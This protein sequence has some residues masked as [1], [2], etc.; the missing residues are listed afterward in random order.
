[1]YFFHET[2]IQIHVTYFIFP[3]I[4][5]LCKIRKNVF[6]KTSPYEKGFRLTLQIRVDM[7]NY[8]AA[9]NCGYIIHYNTFSLEIVLNYR[10]LKHAFWCLF[11]VRKIKIPALVRKNYY[12]SLVRNRTFFSRFCPVFFLLKRI[13]A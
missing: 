12:F 10:I 1:M 11:G 5:K 8:N 6:I 9:L 13:E 2:R 4:R 7:A 3:V